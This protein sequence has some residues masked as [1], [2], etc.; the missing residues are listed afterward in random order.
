M[1]N[2][3]MVEGA[4]YNSIERRLLMKKIKEFDPN[5][6]FSSIWEETDKKFE[7]RKIRL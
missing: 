3:T 4:D 5:F 6:D 1:S 7:K 2:F